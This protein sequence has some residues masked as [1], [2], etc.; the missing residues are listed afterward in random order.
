[1]FW[2]LVQGFVNQAA[3]PRDLLNDVARDVPDSLEYKV[4][5]EHGLF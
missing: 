5:I 2:G 3:A 1:M 4:Q